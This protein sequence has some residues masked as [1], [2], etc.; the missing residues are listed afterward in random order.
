MGD[1]TRNLDALLS[2][3]PS[4]PNVDQGDEPTCYDAHD[5]S[6]N[7]E[8][9][10]SRMDNGPVVLIK[11]ALIVVRILDLVNFRGSMEMRP[12]DGP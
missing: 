3:T 12:N 7:G 1:A 6:M 8:S 10:R 2:K 9:E 5:S 4:A 11:W